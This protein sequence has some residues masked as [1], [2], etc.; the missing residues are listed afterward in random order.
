MMKSKKFE[1]VKK[2]DFIINLHPMIMIINIDDSAYLQRGRILFHPNYMSNFLYSSMMS[3]VLIRPIE[4]KH[5]PFLQNQPKLKIFYIQS[6][7]IQ[8]D[9]RIGD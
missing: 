7:I 9:V 1:K 8:H 5:F 3:T 2:Y 4:L 6:F